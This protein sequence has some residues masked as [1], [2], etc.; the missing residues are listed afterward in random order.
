VSV[1]YFYVITSRRINY[2]CRY[3]S[4]GCGGF[5]G[6]KPLVLG[7]QAKSA[8]WKMEQ[9][10]IEPGKVVLGMRAGF[11]A[12]DAITHEPISKFHGH[13]FPRELSSHV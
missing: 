10:G 4:L 5:H 1:S 9:G 2:G 12:I 7:S 11:C 3:G 6:A 13:R 8:E